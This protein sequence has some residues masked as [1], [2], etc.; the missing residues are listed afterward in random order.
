[1]KKIKLSKA[2]LRLIAQERGKKGAIK[3]SNTNFKLGKVENFQQKDKALGLRS[4]QTGKWGEKRGKGVRKNGV[5]LLA[6][7]EKREPGTKVSVASNAKWHRPLKEKG[8]EKKEKRT[9]W[10]KGLAKLGH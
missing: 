7:V 2:T 10:K 5:G 6:P 8:A 3:N 9:T 4:S 1:L